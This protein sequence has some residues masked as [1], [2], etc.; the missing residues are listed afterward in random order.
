V[1]LNDLQS[2]MN[3]C[4]FNPLLYIAQAKEIIEGKRFV[5]N[6][7]LEKFLISAYQSKLFNEWLM[8]RIK[9]SNLF[10]L[11]DKELLSLGYKKELIKFIKNFHLLT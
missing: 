7:R 4:A 1:D 5:K 2:T 9:L 3:S 6:R 8:E 11:S 10:E